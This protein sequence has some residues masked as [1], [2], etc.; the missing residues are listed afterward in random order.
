LRPIL[1]IYAL[2]ICVSRVVVTAHHPSDVIGGGLMGIVGVMLVARYFAVR[3]LGFSVR[4]DGR[5]HAYPGPSW[6]RIKSVARELLA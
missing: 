3:R 5:L 4:P 2:L 6:R 1:L